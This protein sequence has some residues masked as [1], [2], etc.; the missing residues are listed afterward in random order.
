M[1]HVHTLSAT[2]VAAFGGLLAAQGP[3]P[4]YEPNFGTLLGSD[5]DVVFPAVAL[6]A[7]FLAFG[8]LFTHIEVS[9]NGF[10]WLGA[11]GNPDSGCCAG[12]GT[13]LAAGAA[14]VCALW[15]DLVTDGINGSGVYHHSLPGR[16]V[17]TWANAFE[18]FDPTNRFTIQLQLGS[19]GDFTVWFHPSTTIAQAPHTGLCGV[20]PGAVSDPGSTNF[21]ASFPWN[22]GAQATLYQQWPVGTFD[23]AQRT[24]EFLPNGVGGW[25][26]H[27]RASCAFVPGTWT[28]FGAGCPLASGI[29]GAS[30][31]ELF[32]GATLDLANREFEL[33]P[34]GAGYL[35]QAIS[36]SFFGGYSTVVPMQDDQVVDQVLPF[37]FPHPGGIC[38]TAGFCSNGFV[39]LDNFNN[40]APAAPFVPAFLG[41]GARIAALWTDL[42]LTAG[43]NAY[44]DATAT[45]AY[46]TWVNAPDFYN[47]ALR[48]TF[49]V[50][51]HSDGRLRLCYQALAVG[52]NRPVL[53][54]YA[55][56]GA[57]YDPGPIDVTANVPF[58]TNNGTLPI[59][60]DAGAASPVLGQLFPLVAGNLRPSALVGLLVLGTQSFPAGVPLAGLGMP[61]CAAYLSLDATLAFV[62]TGMSTTLNML[63]IPGNLTF[64]GFPLHAQLAVLDPGITPFG[65][66]A[67]NGG[68]LTLGLY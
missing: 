56:G 7:P 1:P 59:T 48:S 3:L 60:L 34:S 18:S 26:L 25:L 17:V 28:T 10:V 37:P 5:D 43:G 29:T 63:T 55:A 19:G 21:S 13:A 39:W 9:S 62:P 68:T 24:I 50:Q 22:S 52:A 42:D 58:A 6:N 20:S 16:D 45:T 40:A 35:V 54:G 36:G 33:T 31:Y 66:A 4:C 41:D 27:D 44:F 61:N 49:Q 67:S 65:L 64:L 23:L 46:C 53:A 51:L 11:N 32:T 38:T 47:P 2:L 57:T 15:M 30:F 8:S 12:T 14:R